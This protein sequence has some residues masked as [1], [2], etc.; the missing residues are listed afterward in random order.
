MNSYHNSTN[1]KG[2][3]LKQAKSKAIKQDDA[4]LAYFQNYD[5]LG[6]TPE[7]ILRSLQIT[8]KLSE[9]RWSNTPIT[10]I[11]RSFSNLQ[12]KGLI[13]KTD[14]MIMGDYGR[15]VHIWKLVK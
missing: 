6:A 3:D 13:R 14:V 10:S 11:R 7:R 12:S 1:I 15:K 4:V 2:A 9:N 8:E 5:G